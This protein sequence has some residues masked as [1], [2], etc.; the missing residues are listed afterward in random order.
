MPRPPSRPRTTA[1]F[2]RPGCSASACPRTHGGM[3]CD[4]RAYMLA[5][6]EIGRYCAA[7]ALTWNMHVC[8]CLWT[9]ALADDLEMTGEQRAEHE[10]R[11]ALHY[12]RIVEAGAVYAQPFSE[13]GAAA[14]GTKAFETTARRVDG[15]WLVN[16][17]KIFASLAGHA[18]YYGVLCT[19][20]AE[21]GLRRRDT[22][23]LAIPAKAQGV[24]VTAP[25][26][27]SGCA[28]QCRATCCSRTCL[29]T[30]TSS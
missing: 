3:G 29:S 27:R 28:G 6:A 9:G 23:Y 8:S 18:D 20:P 26:I 11:R 10:R 12:R 4:Y 7:T 24:V 19:E 13:G 17:R 30:T 16:G 2:T 25:G 14:A 21:G 5:G 1:T 22:L 15:G